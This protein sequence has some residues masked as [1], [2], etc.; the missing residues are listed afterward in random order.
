MTLEP[1]FFVL[2]LEEET[3]EEDEASSAIEVALSCIF[4]GGLMAK[5]KSHNFVYP[6]ASIR[7]F[8]GF[9]L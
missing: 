5:P 6:S 1:D 2:T 3:E 7:T 9:K 8:S 4:S